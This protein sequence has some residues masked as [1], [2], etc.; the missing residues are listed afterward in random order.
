MKA[1]DNLKN[2][3][4]GKVPALARPAYTI[5]TNVNRAYL[6]PNEVQALGEFLEATK[7][8]RTAA[9]KAIRAD[10]QAL[11][12]GYAK[13]NMQTGLTGE[14]KGATNIHRGETGRGGKRGRMSERVVATYVHDQTAEDRENEERE[15]LETA[16]REQDQR[17]QSMEQAMEPEPEDYLQQLVDEFTFDD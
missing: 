2:W 10:L 16:K 12:D 6:M 9:Y 17:E 5:L 14:A 4:W 8:V 15:R 7:R 13:V 11:A 3:P 1:I